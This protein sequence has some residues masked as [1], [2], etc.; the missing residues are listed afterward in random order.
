M[1]LIELKAVIYLQGFYI[2]SNIMTNLRAHHWPNFHL[3]YPSMG[4]IAHQ[5][6][7]FTN[8]LY[9]TSLYIKRGNKVTRLISISCTQK[10]CRDISRSAQ[11]FFI[12]VKNINN[13]IYIMKMFKLDFVL[14]HMVCQKLYLFN[15]KLANFIVFF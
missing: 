1:F 13:S 14:L 4:F 2:Y 3:L 11:N 7:E 12:Q 15:E 9:A 5:L 10:L 8:L 6:I